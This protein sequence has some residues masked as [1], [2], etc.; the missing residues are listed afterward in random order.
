MTS[1]W[2]FYPRVGLL[3]PFHLNI[4]HWLLDCLMEPLLENHLWRCEIAWIAWNNFFSSAK[5]NNQ[6][7][8]NPNRN[9]MRNPNTKLLFETQCQQFNHNQQKTQTLQLD[10]HRKNRCL[11]IVFPCW[12]SWSLGWFRH[13]YQTNAYL[14]KIILLLVNQPTPGHVPP[15]RNSRPYD[16]GLWRPIGFP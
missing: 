14:E 11:T 4:E 1:R 7:F 10:R 16:H 6:N 9:P 3:N 2:W 8:A 13:I 15:P 5:I 12:L